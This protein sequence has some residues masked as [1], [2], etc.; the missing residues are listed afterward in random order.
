MLL[1]A[2]FSG[3][4][5]TV[6]IIIGKYNSIV[7]SVKS[8]KCIERTLRRKGV[9]LDRKDALVY[10][11]MCKGREDRFFFFSIF[12]SRIARRFFTREEKPAPL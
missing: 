4:I 1:K 6:V 11:H 7:M 10:A 3:F 2:Q 12:L 9:G 8:A 5:I